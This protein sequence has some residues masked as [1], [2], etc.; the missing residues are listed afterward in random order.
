MLLFYMRFYQLNDPTVNTKMP[1]T[2]KNAPSFRV[3][4]NTYR[5]QAYN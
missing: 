2:L 5:H 1:Q 4:T 3:T